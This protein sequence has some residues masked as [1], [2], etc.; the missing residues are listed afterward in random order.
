MVGWRLENSVSIDLSLEDR[1]VPIVWCLRAGQHL[2]VSNSISKL[3]AA[4]RS[5]R[6]RIYDK[7]S[8]WL[9]GKGLYSFEARRYAMTN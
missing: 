2:Q 5:L 8:Y 9:T 6:L 4:L 7:L 1:P 3:D